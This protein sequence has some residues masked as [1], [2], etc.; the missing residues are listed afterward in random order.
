[1]E[2]AED[3]TLFRST[4]LLNGIKRAMSEDLAYARG[5]C[6]DAESGQVIDYLQQELLA[7][8][9]RLGQK[10]ASGTIQPELKLRLAITDMQA[11]WSQEQRAEP[12]RVGF[13]ATSGNPLHWGHI[14]MMLRR[15]EEFELN[16][17]V[18]QVMGDHPHKRATRLPKEQ[19]HIIAQKGLAYF[20]PLLRYSP[21]GYHNLKIGEEN[22]AEFL[23]LNDNLPLEVYFLAGTDVLA[24]ALKNVEAC[25]VLLAAAAQAT[26]RHMAIELVSGYQQ[27]GDV[28][29]LNA[30]SQSVSWS[31]RSYPDWPSYKGIRLSSTLFRRY[32][33]LPL[34]PREAF[35][36][37]RRGD[38]YATARKPAP[39]K[40]RDQGLCAN[41]ILSFLVPELHQL[42]E[43]RLRG[44][45]EI[46]PLIPHG[47]S[48]KKGFLGDRPIVLYKAAGKETV[49]VP[50]MRQPEV[51]NVIGI[52]LCGALQTFLQ[53][54]DIIIP[55][56][57]IRGEG[58]TPYWI[59][60]RLPAAPT[61]ELVELLRA[62]AR[63]QAIATHAGPLYTTAS[64]ARER[65][66]L[67]RYAPFGVLGVEMELA[68]H[69]T[70]AR[71][72]HKSAAS[73]YLVSD[74]VA[75]GES[76][77]QTGITVT[78][79]L[80]QSLANVIGILEQ[81]DVLSDG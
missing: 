22:A 41:V 10:V 75:Q 25:N 46:E 43:N 8:M 15:M 44:A 38:M 76:I 64:L 31:G 16:C 66:I 65:Q 80:Q 42:L 36:T 49:L 18:V 23:L 9:G 61:F 5:L 77:L 3:R 4:Q 60:P 72:H 45:R 48:G 39:S 54:G 53:S 28:S 29:K 14:L 40:P 81:S 6:R 34:L 67:E 68:L 71:L 57:A 19:R 32:P 56:L 78:A 26:G 35:A 73:L 1:M 63:Q 11:Q 47:I 20:Y 79:A 74:N 52:G 33:D 51:T 59:D 55:T 50:I 2:S 24:A 62:A 70:L 69:L 7:V 30:L 58:I 37:V 13:F 12:K 21:L 17:V 27:E